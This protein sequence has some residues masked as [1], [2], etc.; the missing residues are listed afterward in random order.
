MPDAGGD[1]NVHTL[2]THKEPCT[3]QHHTLLSKTPDSPFVDAKNIGAHAS[4]RAHHAHSAYRKVKE[5][6]IQPISKISSQKV[7]GLGHGGPMTSA[8]TCSWEQNPLKNGVPFLS[9]ADWM[10]PMED[11]GLCD[12]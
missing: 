10:N 12:Q 7:Q 4:L 2:V 6:L 8:S 9:K 3:H 5:H 11:I 1:A